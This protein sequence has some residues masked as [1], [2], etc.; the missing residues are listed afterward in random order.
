MSFRFERPLI[1]ENETDPHHDRTAP[2]FKLLP[3]DKDMSTHSVPDS[4][5]ASRGYSSSRHI[6]GQNV[7]R[8]PLM[9]KALTNTDRFIQIHN[10]DSG[11]LQSDQND[12][13]ISLSSDD[14]SNS[15]DTSNSN[16]SIKEMTM[17]EA[18]R[19]RQEEWAERGAAKIVKEVVNPETGVTARHVIKKGIKDFKFGEVL[20]DGSYS[21][22]MLARSIDSGKK[23]AVKVLNKEYLIRQKKVK[24]VNI[25]KNTLQRLNDGRGI[26]KLYFTFQDEAS[27]YFLLEYAPNG[28]FLSVI[29]KYGSLNQECAVYYS[30]QILDAIDYLHQ[31][32]VIHRDIKPENILLDK[33]MKVKLTDFG[34]AKLVGKDETTQAY[35]LLERSK[36]FVGT[37]EYVSPEL[38]NDNYVDYKCDIWA[39]GCILFQM[40]AGKPPFKATNEYLTFQKVMKVQYAFTAGFPL[41]IRDLIKQILVKSPEQRLDTFQVKKHHFFKDTNFGDGSVWDTDPPEIAPYKITAK[42][43]Q[44]V[45][46]LKESKPHLIIN[47]PKKAPRSSSSSLPTT[48]EPAYENK[49]PVASKP[50]S[51]AR[52]AQILENAK[53]E[54]NNRRQNNRRTTSAASAAAQALMKK[55]PKSSPA[56]SLSKRTDSSQDGISKTA[57]PKPPHSAPTV[58]PSDRAQSSAAIS[59]AMNLAPAV[60]PMSKT[61]IF[62]SFYLK[63]LDERVVKMGELEMTTL[64]TS[65]LEKRITKLGASLVDPEKSSQRTTLLSQV[66]RSGGGVTGFRNESANSVLS[67]KDYYLEWDIP[68]DVVSESFKRPTAEESDTHVVSNKFKKLFQVKAEETEKSELLPGSEFLRKV[69]VITTFGRCL[70]FVKRNKLQPETNLFFDLEYD[71]NLSQKGAKIKEIVGGKPQDANELNFAIETPFKSFIFKCDASDTT[72]LPSLTK[73]V[74]SNHDR[75]LLKNKVEDP[76]GIASRAAQLASPGLASTA[77]FGNEASSTFV[78]AS[79]KSSS[80]PQSPSLTK[81]PSKSSFAL[82]ASLNSAGGKQERLFD[83]FVSSKGKQG[84]KHAKP[85]PLSGKLVNGLPTESPLNDNHSMQSDFFTKNGHSTAG[86]SRVISGKSSRM[87]A[88]SDRPIRR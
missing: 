54:I 22:V 31:K 27:L 40:I 16:M 5:Q 8:P 32:G 1:P 62:W 78:R 71:V 35:N 10:G 80:V 82:S 88:R 24:Y 21:T 47:M 64:K 81:S 61:D 36:S 86:T 2:G 53:R 7:P 17:S 57:S 29:K 50:A 37:A 26:I 18:M 74:K 63:S 33:D 12:D 49:K 6:Y 3:P 72:W 76:S 38:L 83:S 85:V 65:F 13:A 30:A 60:P 46:A 45:P 67:E 58:R 79:P 19:R 70:I 42:A 87:L 66:A 75:L 4:L 48:P 84:K 73:S 15:A 14:N 69:A 11:Q 41:V 51:D 59:T 43:M 39:F 25:E 52:T 28:D 77:S 9:E 20:G 56:S 68:E 44:P 23:Y 34:T 55:P